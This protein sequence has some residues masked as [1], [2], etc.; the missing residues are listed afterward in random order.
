M[1]KLANKQTT[2]LWNHLRQAFE[3]LR[4]YDETLPSVKSVSQVSPRYK[5]SVMLSNT[6][7]QVRLLKNT[8]ETNLDTDLVHEIEICLDREFDRVFFKGVSCNP[9]TGKRN[10]VSTEFYLANITVYDW[11]QILVEL[12]GN[13]A[14]LKQVE[15]LNLGVRSSGLGFDVIEGFN[16]E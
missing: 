10:G 2:E 7:F 14:T 16:Y 5:A 15:C 1:I 12:V 11:G 13:V 3:A 6:K 4:N 9:K 8:V